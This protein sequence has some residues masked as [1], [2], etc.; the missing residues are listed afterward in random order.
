VFNK[1][2]PQAFGVLASAPGLHRAGVEHLAE[3]AERLS[4]VV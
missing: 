3:R 2:M 4:S 1:P